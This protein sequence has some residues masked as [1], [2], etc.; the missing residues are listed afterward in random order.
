MSIPPKLSKS[1]FMSYLKGNS[2]L[3]IYDRHPEQRRKWDK[4]FWARGY[5]A[6]TIGIITEKVIK[7]YIQAQIEE[8][9]REKVKQ[10]NC[11]SGRIVTPTLG[12]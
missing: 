3:M 11:R 6:A 7:E 12:G 9:K 8:D 1:E 5:Y 10:Q 2:A 4:S